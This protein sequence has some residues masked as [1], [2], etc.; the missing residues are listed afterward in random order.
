VNFQPNQTGVKKAFFQKV[1]HLYEIFQS[2]ENNL[3]IYN[4][5]QKFF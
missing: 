3:D 2:N 5:L 1:K 4:F